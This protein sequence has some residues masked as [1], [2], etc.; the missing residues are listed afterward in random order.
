M[1]K[2]LT[3]FK[4]AVKYYSWKS[5]RKG[6]RPKYCEVY[7]TF[8]GC[9]NKAKYTEN[10]H[11]VCGSHASEEC[12]ARAGRTKDQPSRIKRKIKQLERRIIRD[13]RMIGK[14]K[15]DKLKMRETDIEMDLAQL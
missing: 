10:G 3:Y 5:K 1:T 15:K 14:L 4:K 11:R 8:A 9:Q 7:D 12:K 6:E 2:K 13:K